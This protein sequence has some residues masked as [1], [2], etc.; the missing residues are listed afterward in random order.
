VHYAE[1]VTHNGA[2]GED[3]V[4]FNLKIWDLTADEKE[5]IMK[6]LR[7][8]YKETLKQQ[9]EEHAEWKRNH[10]QFK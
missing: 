6:V 1:T 7:N 8:I 2:L 9:A 4:W 10:P 3:L 5:R